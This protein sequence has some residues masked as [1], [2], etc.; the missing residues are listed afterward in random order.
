[1]RN[2]D[3]KRPFAVYN[4]VYQRRRS[5][6]SQNKTFTFGLKL[7]FMSTTYQLKRW[8]FQRTHS[9]YLQESLLMKFFRWADEQQFERLLWLGFTFM[10][11]SCVLTPLTVMAALTSGSDFWVVIGA[12]LSISIV[13]ITSLAAL[14]TRI[15]IPVFFLSVVIDLVLIVYSLI[16][17][18]Q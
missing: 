5:Y 7:S 2:C 13:V 11:H 17:V 9:P 15:T 8:T 6:N 14:P 10:F 18:I 3:C 1:M 12:V 4:H 16:Q